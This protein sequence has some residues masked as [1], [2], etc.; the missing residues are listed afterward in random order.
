MEPGNA[1]RHGE[2]AA[3][4]RQKGKSPL[5]IKR[6]KTRSLDDRVIWFKVVFNM[7]FRE[8]LQII[9][10]KYFLFLIVY[11]KSIQAEL[12]RVLEF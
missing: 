11:S 8:T 10:L 9:F 12:F 3:R 2:E 4:S 5:K 6:S 7:I 1:Q